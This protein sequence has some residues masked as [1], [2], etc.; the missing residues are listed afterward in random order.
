MKTRGWIPGCLMS[1]VSVQKL[2]CGICSAFKCSFDE[3]VGKKVVSPS[4]SSAILGPPLEVRS[5]KSWCWQILAPSVGSREDSFLASCRNF[6]WLLAVLHIL[7]LVAASLESLHLS[8]YGFLLC[9]SLSFF[10]S[11]KDILIGFSAHSNPVWSHVNLSLIVYAMSVFLSVIFW[12]SRW[13]WI[14]GGGEGWH[15]QP[16]A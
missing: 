8:S 2:F 10:V 16:T 1:S 7:W 9:V 3:F 15:F 12:G 4:C 5:L 6:W 13:T 14:F 11:D